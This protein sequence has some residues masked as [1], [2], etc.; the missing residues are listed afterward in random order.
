MAAPVAIAT[1]Q[2]LADWIG[3]PIEPDTPDY[4]RAELCL[5]IASSLVRTEAGRTWLDP[6]GALI[7]PVDENAVMV[8]LYCAGRVFDNREALT[9]EGIDDWSGSMRVDEAG[10]YLTATE[11][12]MLSH[13]GGSSFGGLGT[14]ATT[15]GDYAPSTGG[16]VPTD[17][18][19]VLFPWY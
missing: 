7:V 19:N 6:E 14:I 10:A 3:A 5:R 12:R 17:T 15:R 2:E 18:P 13:L 4:R 11:K 16:W 1:V 8:T 9:R